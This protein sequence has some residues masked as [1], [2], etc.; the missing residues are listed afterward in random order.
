MRTEDLPRW[1][2]LEG[3]ALSYADRASHPSDASERDRLLTLCLANYRASKTAKL[4][5]GVRP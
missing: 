1:R 4:I 3:L 5:A 2:R